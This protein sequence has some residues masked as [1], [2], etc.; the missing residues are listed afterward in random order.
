MSDSAA[1][2]YDTLRNGFIVAVPIFVSALFFCSVLPNWVVGIIIALIVLE[3][4]FALF[5]IHREITRFGSTGLEVLVL[6]SLLFAILV[7]NIAAVPVARRIR[8]ASLLRSPVRMYILIDLNTKVI[9][10]AFTGENG[11]FRSEQAITYNTY[12]DTQ[13]CRVSLLATNHTHT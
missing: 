13:G 3:T 7:G 12:A 5:L 1:I 11:G 4:G 9:C 6:P 10:Q 2:L 8:A